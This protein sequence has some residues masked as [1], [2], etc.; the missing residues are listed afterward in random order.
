LKKKNFLI[1]LLC[2]ILSIGC[3]QS[4]DTIT[5]IPNDFRGTIK[6]NF[7]KEN[8]TDKSFEK[9]KRIY[10]IPE[11]GILNTK[12]EPQFGYH[13]QEYYLV[14][15]DGK[16]TEISAILNLNKEIKDTLDKNKI[17]AYRFMNMGKVVK[18][19]SLGNETLQND[20]GIIFSVGNPLD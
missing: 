6:I 9:N 11:S 4:E 7:N 13:F 16:R 17:Y 3:T 5:L 18:I 1:L 10:K 15:K 19:D 12:F 20:Y 14:S 2:G 8:G